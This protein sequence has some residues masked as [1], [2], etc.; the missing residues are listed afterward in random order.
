MPRRRRNADYRSGAEVVFSQWLDQRGIEYEYEQHVLKYLSSVTKGICNKC[1][2]RDV[3]QQRT[4][5]PDFY[6]PKFDFFIEVKG[7]LDS[8][9]RKKMRD[10]R[11]ENPDVDVRLLLMADNKITPRKPERYSDWCKKF[12]YQYCIKFPPDAWFEKET[13]NVHLA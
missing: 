11:R 3:G 7:R 5:T 13:L 1:D 8:A 12:D 4:Y 10:V 6:F 2:S 9:T